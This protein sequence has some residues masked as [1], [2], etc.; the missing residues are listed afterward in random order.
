MD[1]TS[2]SARIDLQDESKR[3][4][5]CDN[6]TNTTTTGRHNSNIEAASAMVKRRNQLELFERQQK[7]GDG[8][9]YCSPLDAPPTGTST[10]L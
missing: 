6:S 8:L 3:A 5:K 7:T 9:H 2:C 10:E 4:A 1:A